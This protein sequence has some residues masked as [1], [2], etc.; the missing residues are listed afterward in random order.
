MAAFFFFASCFLRR[1]LPHCP[2]RT[3]RGRYFEGAK[4]NVAGEG[5]TPVE[6]SVEDRNGCATDHFIS[7]T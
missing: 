3:G 5:A 1:A 6:N 7:A 2:S 4:A